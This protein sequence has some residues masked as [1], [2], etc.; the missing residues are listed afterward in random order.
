M[1]LDIPG[2]LLRSSFHL[3]FH[4]SQGQN[5]DFTMFCFDESG[6][7]DFGFTDVS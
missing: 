3:G 5:D 7:H 6:N 1:K 4:H 2:L